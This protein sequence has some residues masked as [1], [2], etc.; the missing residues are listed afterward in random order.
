[1]LKSHVETIEENMHTIEKMEEENPN[2]E[3]ELKREQRNCTAAQFDNEKIKLEAI[4]TIEQFKL[5]ENKMRGEYKE[6][7]NEVTEYKEMVRANLEDIKNKVDAVI[8]EKDLQI[9]NLHASMMVMHILQVKM[10]ADQEKEMKMAVKDVEK[11]ME[12]MSTESG[13]QIINL[14]ATM[15]ERKMAVEVVE[16][17][18]EAMAT[19]SGLQIRNLQAT[20]SEKKVAMEAVVTEKE[21][22][23][24]NLQAALKEKE[25]RKTDEQ[26]LHRLVAEQTGE[27]LETVYNMV[28]EE[29]NHLIKVLGLNQQA[30][31]GKIDDEVLENLR[32][33]EK[34]LKIMLDKATEKVKCK[35]CMD[36]D[37]TTVFQPCGHLCCC[38]ECARDIRRD[39]QPSAA[40]PCCPICNGKIENEINVFIS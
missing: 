28:P 4:A 15:D 29:R 23:I 12:A 1:M 33:Q 18:M 20:M 31:K 30:G 22:Q 5:N 13:L 32:L 3:N 35:I 37:M 24:E 25:E 14:Q 34:G 26:T 36:R 16:K 2:F 8:I 38:K 21:R 6:K 10:A 7:V 9:E 17:K 40:S 11:K 27:S 39:H 19:V